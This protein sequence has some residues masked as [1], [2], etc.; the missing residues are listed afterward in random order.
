MKK[1]VDLFLSALK[2]HMEYSFINQL[3]F[4]VWTSRSKHKAL[5]VNALFV[6]PSPKD[7]SY[8]YLGHEFSSGSRLF[9]IRIVWLTVEYIRCSFLTFFI[10]LVDLFLSIGVQGQPQYSLKYLPLNVCKMTAFRLKMAVKK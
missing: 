9:N 2:R 10:K 1:P 7:K 8:G 3:K 6:S 5:K 4:N